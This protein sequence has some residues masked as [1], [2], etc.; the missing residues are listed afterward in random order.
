MRNSRNRHARAGTAAREANAMAI[1][2]QADATLSPGDG[3][4]AVSATEAAFPGGEQVS[5]YTYGTRGGYGAKLS[6]LATVYPMDFST[7]M[8]PGKLAVIV[9][10]GTILPSRKQAWGEPSPQ[11]IA[12]LTGGTVASQ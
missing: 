2:R 3:S 1:A 11:Q 10:N 8:L 6:R 9:I 5:V 4:Y 7:I 12:R